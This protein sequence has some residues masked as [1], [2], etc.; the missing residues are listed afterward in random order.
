MKYLFALVLL[1][2]FF[3]HS[4]VH[5]KEC[6]KIT[7]AD[8]N[9]PSAEFIA[10][11][12]LFILNYGYGCDAELVPGDTMPT[13]ISMIE[14]GEPDIAP[15]LW[16]NSFAKPLEKA[17]SKNKL[18]IAGRSLKNGGEEGFW[19]PKYLVEK[20]PA[21]SNING[22]YKYAYLFTYSEEPGKSVFFGC[23]TGWNCEISAKNLFNALKLAD[24]GFVI[25]SPGSAAA[26]DGSLAK[27]Y[28]R[29]L[30]WF[31]Y[32]W[33]PTSLLGKYEMV[34]VDFG[35]GINEEHF[36]SCITNSEC[37][38]P[39]PTMYPPSPVLTVTT[40]SFAEKFQEAFGYLQKRSFSNKE[41]NRILAWILDNQAD[42]LA[43]SIYFLKNYKYLW[44][45][46]VSEKIANKIET[47]LIGYDNL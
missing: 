47:H 30:P 10:Y 19:I 33:A 31:G 21:L 20:Y 35:S 37:L 29:R 4:P 2:K 34:K 26:L 23:P 27:A 9:W 39:K 46:W 32:Y 25:I 36:K 14:R 17:I 16:S 5:A 43:A 11:V 28:E 13:G 22:V 1:I 38:Q 45:T 24:H 7:I 15:E 40:A 8:M 18:R 42:G 41:M 6:G 3:L 44:K 12:D